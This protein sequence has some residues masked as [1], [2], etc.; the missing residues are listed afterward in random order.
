MNQF[1]HVGLFGVFARGLD[2]DFHRPSVGQQA[3]T[4]RVPLRQTEAVEQLVCVLQ[5]ESGPGVT[6]FAFCT[7]GFAAVLCSVPP[8]PTRNR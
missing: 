5:I 7:A 4:A 1:R 3:N 6:V 2:D 8:A